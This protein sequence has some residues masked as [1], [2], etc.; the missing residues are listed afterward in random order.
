MCCACG[1][2]N[3]CPRTGGQE[4]RT[5]GGG[6]KLVPHPYAA[7]R[8]CA[9]WRMCMHVRASILSTWVGNTRLTLTIFRPGLVC[10]TSRAPTRLMSRNRG[11]LSVAQQQHACMHGS[12]G[13]LLHH[14]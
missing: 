7:S 4:V 9:L 14:H 2:R 6:R 5:Q 12:V 13:Q 1:L 11:L 10:S 3:G 8:F